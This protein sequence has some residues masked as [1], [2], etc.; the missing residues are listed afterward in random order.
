MYKRQ[1]LLHFVVIQPVVQIANMA[2]EVSLGQLGVPGYVRPGKDE[3]SSLSQSFKR[4][5][6]SLEN[7]MRMLDE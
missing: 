7:A 6:L 4:M 1:I 3:I 2:N 5:R